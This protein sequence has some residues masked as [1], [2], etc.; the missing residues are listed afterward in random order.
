M[1]GLSGSGK[2]TL[3]YALDHA[4]AA[5]GRAAYVLDGDNVRH[6]LSSD[7]GF[8]PEDRR[9]NIRRVAEVARLFADANIITI[10]SFI[11]PYRRDREFARAL[12]SPG[13]FV[14]VYMRIP[15]AVCERRDPKGLYKLAR[16]G[17]LKAFT[18]IDDPYEEPEAPEIVMEVACNDGVLRP[19]ELM[20]QHLLDYLGNKGFLSGPAA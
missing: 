16:A 12:I 18:G 19:P 5:A 11:S 6:G 17:K 1:T 10:V 4:L 9:E 7:L 13:S 15:L 14:E 3:A 2:S 8:S 20:A